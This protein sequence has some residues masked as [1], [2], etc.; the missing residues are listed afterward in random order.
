VILADYAAGTA[1]F[2]SVS[3]KREVNGKKSMARALQQTPEQ[4]L[5]NPFPILN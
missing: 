4:R 2:N 5:G 1:A 3:A